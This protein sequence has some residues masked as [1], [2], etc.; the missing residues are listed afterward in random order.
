MD[1]QHDDKNILTNGTIYVYKEKD[2]AENSRIVTVLCSLA[3]N[4]PWQ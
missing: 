3:L 4:M 1:K 2:G